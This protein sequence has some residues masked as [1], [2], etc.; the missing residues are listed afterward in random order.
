MARTY[1]QRH[2]TNTLVKASQ[3]LLDTP[4]METRKWHKRGRFQALVTRAK[5]GKGNLDHARAVMIR[6][7]N[8]VAKHNA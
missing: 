6:R 7:L 1:T 4:G 8:N 5:G 2:S 3:A